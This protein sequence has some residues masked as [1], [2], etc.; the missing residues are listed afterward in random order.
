MK[1]LMSTVRGESVIELR[2]P[3]KKYALRRSHIFDTYIML[4]FVDQ[5]NDED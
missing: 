1:C 3:V 5:K 4:S 2:S